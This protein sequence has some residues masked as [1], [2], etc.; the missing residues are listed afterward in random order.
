MHWRRKILRSLVMSVL[1]LFISGTT[2]SESLGNSSDTCAEAATAARKAC[3]RKAEGAFWQ[4]AGTCVAL[5]GKDTQEACI[6]I[7]E[8][9]RKQAKSDCVERFRTKLKSCEARLKNHSGDPAGQY[10]QNP[11]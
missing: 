8:A 6:R 4:A 2:P 3:K 7:A 5:P 11:D 9:R 10:P 1:T